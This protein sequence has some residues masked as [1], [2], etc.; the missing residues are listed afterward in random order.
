[1][2]RTIYPK[3]RF[4]DLPA[5]VE[6]IGVHRAEN[7]RLRVG[8]IIMWSAI[9]TIVLVAL[10]V[11]GT[12]LATGRLG[13]GPQAPPTPVADAPAVEAVVDTTYSVLVL[14]ATDQ[15]GLASSMSETII[16]GGWAA[17]DIIAGE[18]GS[19]DFPTTTVYYPTA[20]DEGAARG[21]AEVIGGAEVARNDSYQ[22]TDDPTT[23]PDESQARQLVV[24]IGLDRTTG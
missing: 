10:G 2:P 19:N 14:N 13:A 18:A 9:A 4:D 1:M 5:D 23:D 16:A 7:P 22:P 24:V 3:D 21:L 6:R 11:F 15:D 8:V 20:D 17:D 12:L